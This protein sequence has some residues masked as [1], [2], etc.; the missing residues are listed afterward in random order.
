[1]PDTHLADIVFDGTRACGVRLLDG[2]I[3]EASW[4]VLCS[5]TYGSPPILMRSQQNLPSLSSQLGK[6]LG[7][8][9]D[10]VAAIEYNPAK[11]RS[12]L[13]LPGYGQFYKGKPITTM[14]YDFWVGRRAHRYDGTRFT[15]QEIFLSSLTNFLY[16]DGRKPAGDPSWW[17]LQKKQAIAHWDNRI[18]LLAMVEKY[19]SEK[20]KDL[21]Q[22]VE[23]MLEK[24][25][26]RFPAVTPCSSVELPTPPPSK[27]T[28][29]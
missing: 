26:T 24:E 2:T 4:V 21:N 14:T 28:R 25:L 13:G 6:N 10:H 9:G 16:D 3:V 17:G 15:L 7:V 23:V 1:M 8:N 22:E 19:Y 20:E 18:E 29:K 27:R 12:V 5:G 11:V